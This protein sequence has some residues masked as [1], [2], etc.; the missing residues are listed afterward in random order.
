MVLTSRAGTRDHNVNGQPNRPA[1]M[2]LSRH[3]HIVQNSGLMGGRITRELRTIPA[4]PADARRS[5]DTMSRSRCHE[6]FRL[7]SSGID[8]DSVGANC[9]ERVGI[10]ASTSDPLTTAR[11]QPMFA[12]A[13][14][15]PQAPG[16]TFPRV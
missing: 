9:W 11:F 1:Y 4:A 6:P 3:R 10:G 12:R 5:T 13:T 15:V 14:D 16:A 7:R 2:R 8:R